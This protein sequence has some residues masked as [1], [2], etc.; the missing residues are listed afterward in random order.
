MT[1]VIICTGMPMSGYEFQYVIVKELLKENRNLIDLGWIEDQNLYKIY[2]EEKNSNRISILLIK[3]SSYI[4]GIFDLIDKQDLIILN[5]YRDIRDIFSTLMFVEG[6]KFEDV[7][8][9]YVYNQLINEHDKWSSHRNSFSI[10]FEN[11]LKNIPKEIKKIADHID[12]KIDQFGVE[13]I[14]QKLINESHPNKDYGNMNI[15]YLINDGGSHK[16][17]L[18]DFQ[19]GIIQYFS[20]NWLIIHNYPIKNT[21]NNYSIIWK[22]KK[23]LNH[24]LKQTITQRMNDKF[25]QEAQRKINL[26]NAKNDHVIFSITPQVK[27]KLYK[28]SE[29]AIDIYS[30]EFEKTERQFI[31]KFLKEGDV[32]FDIGA[33]IGLFTLIASEK[34]GILGSIHAFEPAVET[35]KRLEEN[36][37]LNKLKNVYL[38][39]IALSDKKETLK[40]FVDKNGYD[41]Y[42]SFGRPSKGNLYSSEE[43]LTWPLD[44]YIEENSLTKIDLVK[45]DVE[46]WEIPVFKGAENLFKKHDAP[47]LMVEFTE[48]NAI[49]AGFSCKELYEM[50][51]YYGYEWFNYD[52]QNNDLVPEPLKKDYPY[53]NLIATKN[54]S[55]VR[56]RIQKT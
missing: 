45:I 37:S 8:S 44:F 52:D 46:G 47:T 31:N 15:S 19:V 42:N 50:G 22:G 40:L 12:V 2:Q 54:P 10:K 27:I 1:K 35:F 38:N 26:L 11:F 7:F 21:I 29:L 30:G 3:T 13:K 34:I 53:S 28:D 56:N 14:K 18:S 55:S 16:I 25:H 24:L 4:P 17:A 41:A 6:K 43:V 9:K 49:N 5:C 32:F 51:I 20:K 39:N 23:I 36:I 48:Q 33:N